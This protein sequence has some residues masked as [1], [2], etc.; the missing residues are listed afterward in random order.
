MYQQFPPPP[1]P[2]RRD[3]DS[4]FWLCIAYPASSV[5]LILATLGMAILFITHH[6]MTRTRSVIFLIATAALAV[7]A[8]FT[9]HACLHRRSL[10]Y[11]LWFHRQLHTLDRLLGVAPPP[12][13]RLLGVN[14]DGLPAGISARAVDRHLLIVGATQSGKSTAAALAAAQDHDRSLLVIDPHAALVESLLRLGVLDGVP[15][16]H[17]FPLMSNATHVATLN[18]LRPFPGESPAACAQRLTEASLDLYFEGDATQAQ[19]HQDTLFHT[20]YALCVAGLTLAEVVPFLADE[21]FRAALTPRFAAHPNLQRWL[22][23]FDALSAS[24]QHDLTESTVNRFRPFQYDELALMFGQRH[25]SIDLAAFLNRPQALLLAPLSVDKFHAKGAYLAAGLL[26]STV[27]ALLARRE[28]GAPN[29]PL[30]VVADEFQRYATAAFDRLL[31]ERRG[32]GASALLVTQGLRPL[33]EHRRALVLNNIGALLAFR[34]SAEEAALL[35]PELF[36]PDPL[37][38]RQTRASGDAE[39]YSHPESLAHYAKQLVSLPPRTAYLRLAPAPAHWLRIS[40][41]ALP[42]NPAA[43]RR[44][45]GL[46]ARIGRPRAE[47]EADLRRRARGDTGSSPAAEV[48]DG[49]V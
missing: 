11:R 2:P 4:F 44:L 43:H 5:F 26:L 33:P 17:I 19:R 47:L 1:H 20:L 46:L 30:R 24:K 21:D 14:A 8:A 10:R 28:K 39:L 12:P 36:A 15:D 38:V 27:D 25:S 18:L 41:L 29:P 32:Y 49:W 3:E 35:A 40:P 34:T 48:A 31:A 16:T 23:H 13:A 6:E 42:P 22:A 37:R 45:D 9:F 7:Y